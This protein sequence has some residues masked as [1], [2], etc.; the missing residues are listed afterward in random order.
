MSNS[1]NLEV[2]SLISAGGKKLTDGQ[3]FLRWIC[4]GLLINFVK[5]KNTIVNLVK[6][7]NLSFYPQ[8]KF[9]FG[10]HFKTVKSASINKPNPNLT[11]YLTCYF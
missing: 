6:W 3:T 9:E 7:F 2:V 8:F 10:P 5:C 4:K 1:G 11:G